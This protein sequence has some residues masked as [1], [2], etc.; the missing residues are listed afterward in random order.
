MIRQNHG[1]PLTSLNGYDPP[2]KHAAG[3]VSRWSAKLT[4][5]HVSVTPKHWFQTKSEI[6]RT[7]VFA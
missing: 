7:M 6:V 1:G 3:D 2:Q 5:K 4:E